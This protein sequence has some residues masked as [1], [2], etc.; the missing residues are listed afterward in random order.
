[1]K[2]TCEACGQEWEGDFFC[3]RC[4]TGG[5]IEVVQSPDIFWSGSP[6]D[7]EYIEE[8]EWIENGDICLNCCNCNLI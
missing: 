7:D 5:H 1:M 3:K 2:K 4:S 8:E 6:F